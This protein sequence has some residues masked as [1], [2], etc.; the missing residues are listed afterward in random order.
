MKYCVIIMF[1][2]NIS[3]IFVTKNKTPVQMPK[4]KKKYR[5]YNQV[6]INTLHV[7][8]GFSKLYIREIV[9][10]KRKAGISE[11]LIKEYESITEDV[12]QLKKSHNQLK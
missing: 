2:C 8:Y 10:G 6:A 11:Q 1:I 4:S 3:Y 12:D 7:K 9:S 5:S